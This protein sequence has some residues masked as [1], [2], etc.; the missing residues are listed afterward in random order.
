V[1]SPSEHSDPRSCGVAIEKVRLGHPRDLLAAIPY[2]LG[3]HPHDSVVV[4]AFS[5]RQVALTLR[6]DVHAVHDAQAVWAQLSRP[7]S[8]AGTDALAVVAYA[9]HDA[10]RA[11][12]Q[13][14]A[15]SPWPVL[16]V[17]R[18]HDGRWWS[19]TC[20]NGPSCCPPGERYVPDPAVTA[21]LAIGTGS[22]AAS[23]RDV[24]A[25]LEPGSVVLVDAVAALLP[26]DPEPAVSVLTGPPIPRTPNAATG[27]S[28]SARRRPRC[29]CTRSA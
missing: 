24:A 9:D 27:R 20:S 3:F 15:S 26:I 22:P 29:C 13:F 25:C 17:L 5:R 14:A 2:L 21:P 19:L 4:V 11:V 6:V 10:E 18:A 16:D 1:N 7:L 12:L 28:R 23:R 8:E